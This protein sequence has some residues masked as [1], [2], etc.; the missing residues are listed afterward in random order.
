MKNDKI[1]IAVIFGGKSSEHEVSRWSAVSVISN[2]DMNKYD[3]VMVGITKIGEW[4][5]YNGAPNKISDG[6]WETEARAAIATQADKKEFSQIDSCGGITIQKLKNIGVSVMIPILHGCMGEDGT[7]QGLFEIADIAYVGC[8]VFASSACMDKTMTKSIVNGTGVMQ[9]KYVL[10]YAHQIQNQIDT[11][12][13]EIER[14]I[15]YY[16]F[17]KPSSSGSSV[18]VSKCKNRSELKAALIEA[19]RYDRKI[20]IEEYIKGREFECA[21][22]GND[23]PKASVVGEIIP[24]AEFYDYEAKYINDTSKTV[25]PAN[26]PEETAE[27]IRMSAL[28]VYQALDCSGLARV[29]FFVRDETNEVIFN[30]INSMPGFTNISMYP[31]MWEATGIPY[32]ELIDR[33]I[34]LALARYQ[35]NAVYHEIGSGDANG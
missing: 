19:V 33:L 23:D 35:E 27:K 9:A 26:I 24:G 14:E 21:I 31:K 13:D 30:E 10:G 3:V 15:G 12:I 7:I 17:V 2:L 16:C 22:L 32:R 4:L 20:L 11:L 29:D 18:G 34:Q 8:G 28:A 25:I 5:I 1:K 6:S